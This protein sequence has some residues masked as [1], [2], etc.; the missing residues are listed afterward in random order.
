MSRVT[1]VAGSGVS[2]A[3]IEPGR[4][5]ADDRIM[6]VNNFFFEDRYYLGK[7]VDLAFVA[8]DPRVAPF[9]F[10]TLDRARALYDV[11]EWTAVPERVAR[12]GRKLTA[13]PERPMRHA[14][15]LVTAEVERLQA[16]YQTQPSGGLRAILLAHAMGARQVV[17]AGIDL[18]QGTQ[19]YVYPPGKHQR[20][21]LGE[22][23]ARRA[24]DLSQH[25]PD[26]D[27]SLL[28]WLADREDLTLWRSA[29]CPALNG[30]LDLAPER[31]GPAL[32]PAPKPRSEIVD[33]ADW[34]GWYPIALLKTLRR[35]R[36]WQRQL[37]GTVPS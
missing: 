18:Y 21:L 8:G 2:L 5:L 34:A 28:A 10:A 36:R 20:D 31:P 17:L 12:A 22:D 1:V 32:A 14:D 19:R 27:R 24:Y 3:A 23:L 9:V 4:I 35:V 37:R 7:R 13:L 16:R 29:D 11:R 15:A 30:L 25:H 33:W 26:L 6:R